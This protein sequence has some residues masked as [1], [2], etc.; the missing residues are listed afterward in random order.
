[1][2]KKTTKHHSSGG[3]L[4]QKQRERIAFREMEKIAAS[5]QKSG[6]EGREKK[7]NKPDKIQT[8][9]EISLT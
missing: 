9:G 5:S 3:E 2:N 8:G 7:Q 4:A 1:V 6:R